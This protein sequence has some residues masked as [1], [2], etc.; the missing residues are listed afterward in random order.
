MET[1]KHF[2][3]NERLVIPEQWQLK[4][5]TI[6]AFSIIHVDTTPLKSS[7]MYEQTAY[8]H[9]VLCVITDLII[10][11]S[12]PSLVGE[13]TCI[14]LLDALIPIGDQLLSMSSSKTA[15]VGAKLGDVIHAAS[16]L[17]NVDQG[18]GHSK[19]CKAAIGWLDT[20]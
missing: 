11:L 9:N 16:I 8:A 6:I 2:H 3:L 13:V 20:W 10:I 5:D 1:Q 14:S 17:A 7:Y 12:Y 18:R 19:L 4:F 15:C